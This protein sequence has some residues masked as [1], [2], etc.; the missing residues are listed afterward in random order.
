[1]GERLHCVMGKI[2]WHQKNFHR[3]ALN[4]NPSRN[5]TWIFG[6]LKEVSTI[7]PMDLL[8]ANHREIAHCI[9]FCG[10]APQYKWGPHSGQHHNL[11]L[12]KV[13]TINE[14]AGPGG[15]YQ[16][17]VMLSRCVEPIKVRVHMDGW[18]HN[19]LLLEEMYETKK[20]SRELRSDPSGDWT[21]KLLFMCRSLI[22]WAYGPIGCHLPWNCTQY[23]LLY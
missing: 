5:W 1:M 17:D 8:G 19:V 2:R 21:W 12:L 9:P 23:P 22:H 7:G 3:S 10:S 16:Q 20:C 13:C 14:G 15:W 4:S 18:H 6:I 11:M